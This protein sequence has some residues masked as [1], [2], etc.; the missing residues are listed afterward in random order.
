MGP[1]IR[2]C[3]AR[4]RIYVRN[5]LKS[6]CKLGVTEYAALLNFQYSPEFRMSEQQETPET[7]EISQK[8]LE[9]KRQ[10]EFEANRKAL[11]ELC[12][13]YPDVF[14]QKDP[15][16]LKIGIHEAIAADGKL[17]K[18]RIRRALNLYVR[19]RK[20]IASLIEGA[21]RVSIGGEIAGQVTADEASHAAEKLA[22]IDKKR[23]Q[24]KPPVDKRRPAADKNRAPKK[25][26]HRPAN[27]TVKPNKAKTNKPNED[28]K[29]AEER[30]QAKLEALVNK[31]SN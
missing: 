21:D 27:P 20:Y 10:K 24:R 23:A 5:P 16:P 26:P 8:K 9:A 31:K 4:F 18:T 19:R 22:E 30:L 25:R 3:F 13:L 15:K 2:L 7:K 17:S 14:S 6:L 1:E 12:E 29:K 28:P 11:E